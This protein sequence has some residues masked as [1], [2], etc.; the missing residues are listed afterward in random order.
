MRVKFKKG[1]SLTLSVIL[2]AAMLTGLLAACSV[3]DIIESDLVINEV[4]TSNTNSLSV[5]GLGSPDWVEIYN[6][7]K[8]DINLNG[9]IL[10]NSSKPHLLCL[11]GHRNSGR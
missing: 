9:Y 11:S 8:N 6:R 10:R 7:S 2:I 4:V 5:P 3:S 1:T